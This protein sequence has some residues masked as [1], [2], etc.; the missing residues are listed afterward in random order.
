MLATHVPFAGRDPFQILRG[1]LEEPVPDLPKNVPAAVRALV[2]QM[3]Q[4][5][6]SDRPAS[7]ADLS[8]GIAQL[9][10]MT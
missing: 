6:P 9:Q 3:L 10:A 4:K 1:H 8:S 5:D 2:I 7:A